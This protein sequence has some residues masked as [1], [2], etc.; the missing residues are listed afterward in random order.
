MENQPQ[1]LNSATYTT[2]KEESVRTPDGTLFFLQM[3]QV[4]SQTGAKIGTDLQVL[5]GKTHQEGMT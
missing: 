1:P 2:V 4:S 3:R 5:I